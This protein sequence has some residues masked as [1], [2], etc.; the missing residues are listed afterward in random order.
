MTLPRSGSMRSGVYSARREL[1][2]RTAV[3]GSSSWPT[4]TAL[5]SQGGTDLRERANGKRLDTVATTWATPTVKGDHNRA[6]L[7]RKAGDGLATQAKG[8]A[9]P[10]ARDGKGSFSTGHGRDLSQ[11]AKGWATPSQAMNAGYASD[12]KRKQPSSGG[13][14][15]GHRGNELLRQARGLQAPTQATGNGSTPASTRRLNPRFVEWLMG[16]PLGWTDCAP[17]E[18]RWS[19]FRQQWRSTLSRLAPVRALRRLTP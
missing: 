12:E 10:A 14:R 11:D 4:P 17:L 18:T 5:V 9:T 16:L 2:P 6:E 7:S 13:H 15:A 8:W 19:Q 1:A 3:N